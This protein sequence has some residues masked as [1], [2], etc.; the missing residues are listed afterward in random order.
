[1][2]RLPHVIKHV[3]HVKSRYIWIITIAVYVKIATFHPSHK[4]LGHLASRA[5]RALHHNTILSLLILVKIHA[6]RKVMVE[7]KIA[8]VIM[9]VIVVHFG[10]FRQFI[11]NKIWIKV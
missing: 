5:I 2:R 4:Q 7:L 1:M 10:L 8:H 9:L 3:R 6:S 11:L